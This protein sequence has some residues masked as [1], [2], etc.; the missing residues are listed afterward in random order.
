MKH[1]LVAAA[2]AASTMVAALA[3]T[4][5][6]AWHGHGRVGVYIGGPM[7]GYGYPYWGGGY[8]YWGGG[9]PYYPYYSAPPVVTVPVTP[10][11]Y[12][13][14]PRAVTATPAPAPAAAPSASGVG[15]WYYCQSPAGYYPSVKTCPA[16]WQKVAPLPE[17]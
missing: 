15:Y 2:L 8:P 4:P 11:T 3:P 5:A 17:Q 1:F 10:P 16:G 6:L 12:I 13:E 9:Y 7:F 14:Q